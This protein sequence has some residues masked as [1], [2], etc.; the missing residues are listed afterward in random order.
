MSASRQRQEL[1]SVTMS[2]D[3]RHPTLVPAAVGSRG[4]SMIGSAYQARHAA[5][6]ERGRLRS[7]AAGVAA[8][9]VFGGAALAVELPA[10]SAEEACTRRC[11]SAV[12]A[13][14][15]SHTSTSV[16]FSVTLTNLLAQRLGSAE[17]T[18]PAG[19]AVT[20]APTT[21]RGT[22]LLVNGVLH[23]R[24]AETPQGE[25]VV[26]SFTGTTPA[27]AGTY[28]WT[29]VAKQANEFNDAA[30]TGNLLQMDRAA[31]DLTTTTTS[32]PPPPFV[33]PATSPTVSCN[34]GTID[35]SVRSAVS[36]GTVADATRFLVGT[37]DFPATNATGTQS[38]TLYANAVAGRYCPLGAE[39]VQCT[40]EMF[41]DEIPYPYVGAFN[42]TL[43]MVCD[44]TVCRALDRL[45]SMTKL[46]EQT[47]ERTFLPPCTPGFTLT[48]FQSERQGDGDLVA[49]V[50]N[51]GPG[52][53]KIAGLMVGEGSG[54]LITPTA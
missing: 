38:Y 53:P 9:L 1:K 16:P 44:V 33:C 27:Q 29:V 11:Y 14:Q 6:R 28:T 26:V 52:D 41:I 24:N 4:H 13:P 5:R 42:A 22:V 32:P 19:Y 31:S 2:S 23:L 37:V 50:R 54:E 51:L 8:T 25:Q 39:T 20:S 30:G 43:T 48:C 47:G 21:T 34:T 46:N 18:P 49:T 7:V 3:M 36:T 35:Y 10:A 12:V 15:S 40:F 45:A 17:I